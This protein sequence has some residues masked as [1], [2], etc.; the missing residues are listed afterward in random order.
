MTDTIGQRR[1]DALTISGGGNDI[2]FGPLGATCLASGNCLTQEVTSAYGG[3]KVI[4]PTR[5][6]QDA[7]GLDTSLAILVVALRNLNIPAS[8]VYLT[9]Y[10]DPTS[11]TDASGTVRSCDEILEDVAWPFHV[12][13]PETLWARTTVLPTL[14]GKLAA[15]AGNE[16]WNFVGGIADD[17]QGH[18]YCVGDH[19]V[20]N[21]NRWIRTATE[22]AAMQGPDDKTKNTGMLHPTYQGHQDYAAHIT[23]AVQAGFAQLPIIG[24]QDNDGVRDSVDNCPTVAN[25]TQADSDHDGI[26][27]ACDAPPP[28][29]PTLSVSDTS[30]TEGSAGAYTNET[31]TVTMSRASTTPVSVDVATTGSTAFAP[32]DYTEVHTTLTFSPGQVTK[33]VSVPVYGDLDTE[34]DESFWLQLSNPVGATIARQAAI[35]LIVDDDAPLTISVPARSVVE[36]NAGTTTKMK[37]SLTLNHAAPEAQSFSVATFSGTATSGVDFTPLNRTV[38]IPAGQTKLNVTVTV[39]GDN[40]QERKETFYLDVQA[41]SAGGPETETVGTIKNDDL[42]SSPLVGPS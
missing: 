1:I 22:S 20:P 8:S 19:D 21:S 34:G 24:D 28:P 40:L 11:D 31:F 18:G 29:P 35:G 42:T 5:F 12:D 14:N 7:R 41:L 36:G 4:L 13:A 33:S 38:T 3:P 26:G 10:P 25:P 2:G 32:G 27:D 16:R 23:P 9:E 15:A 39:I 17:F 37:F 6:E 30:I